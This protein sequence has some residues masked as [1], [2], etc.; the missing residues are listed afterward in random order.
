VMFDVNN[1]IVHDLRSDAGK[2]NYSY[3]NPD[4]LNFSQNLKH[5]LSEGTT[6]I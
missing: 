2:K 1:V 5:F 6:I 3:S 4:H